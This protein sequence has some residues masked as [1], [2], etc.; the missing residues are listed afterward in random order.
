MPAPVVC[1]PL[2]D[3][4]K[5]GFGVPL[6]AWFRGPLRRLPDEILL[7][8]R[9]LGRG[10]F[11]RE[12]VAGLIDDHLTGRRDNSSRIWALLQLELWLRM[13]VDPA[14]EPAPVTVSAT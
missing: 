7:D 6:A 12:Y 9:A 11:R 2:V 8:P 5:S 3:R 1:P 4:A 14:M 13:Y 10:Y